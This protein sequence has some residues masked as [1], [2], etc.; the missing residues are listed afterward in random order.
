MSLE[1]LLLWRIKIP[2]LSY[3][4]NLLCCPVE[5]DMKPQMSTETSL[6][7]RCFSVGYARNLG[8]SY[9]ILIKLNMQIKK[10]KKPKNP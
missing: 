4:E 10:I 9:F 1:A 5:Q 8:L 7:Q 6:Q 2:I 3:F